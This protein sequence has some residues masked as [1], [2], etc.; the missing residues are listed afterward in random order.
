MP[1]VDPPI[2]ASVGPLLHLSFTKPH[3]FYV[4]PPNDKGR[5]RGRGMIVVGTVNDTPLH[6]FSMSNVHRSRSIRYSP[7]FLHP[8]P[9]VVVTFPVLVRVPVTFSVQVHWSTNCSENQVFPRF[10]VDRKITGWI[11]VFSFFFFLVLKTQF[12]FQCWLFH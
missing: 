12:R 9:V 8:S 1:L 6:S 10:R 4:W 5:D 3:F 2:R 7:L 11:K